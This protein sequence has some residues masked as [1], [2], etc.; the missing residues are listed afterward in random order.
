[1]KP[2]DLEAALAGAPVVRQK[3]TPKHFYHS[4]KPPIEQIF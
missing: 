3:H 4:P 1:M 2:F